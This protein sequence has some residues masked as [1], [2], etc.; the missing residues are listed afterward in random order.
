MNSTRLP[1]FTRSLVVAH[2]QLTERDCK[3]IRLVDRHR[4]LRSSQIVALIDG[5]S[6]SILRRLKLLYHHGFLERPRAQL[7]Y[8][9]QSGSHHIIYGLGN[10]GGTLL[11]QEFGIA[12]RRVSWGEKNRAVGRIFLEHALL[13]SDVMVTIELAC[14]KRG[15]RLLTEKELAPPDKK[16]PF[17]CRVSINN[18]LKHEIIPDRVFALEFPDAD[19]KHQRRYF[20]LEADR[21]TMPVKR[22]NLSQTSFYR[23]LLA[24][25]ATWS[26]NLHRTLFGF[27]RFRVITVTTI[28]GRRESLMEV[29]SELERGR[30]LFLFADHSIL[31]GDIFSPV[32]RT[33]NP[34]ETASLLD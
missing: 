21:G 33:G 25:E 12:L 13:V 27:N 6:Q 32:W 23:K 29:C 1:R 9:R 24:Y 16:Q 22:R 10:K 18:R 5:S 20:F 4:F 2:I 3:I 17:R 26:Q 31:S 28:P 15:F 8:Y 19:G 34:A 7:E 11:K 14:R 30:G